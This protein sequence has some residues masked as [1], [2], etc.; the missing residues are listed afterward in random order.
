MLAE[1]VVERL[2]SSGGSEGK[3]SRARAATEEQYRSI[4]SLSN[5]KREQLAADL[6]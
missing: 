5:S 6:R 3:R 1:Y 4:C 2:R